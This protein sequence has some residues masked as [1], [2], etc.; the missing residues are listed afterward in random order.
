MYLGNF[1]LAVLAGIGFDAVRS[2]QMPALLWSRLTTVFKWLIIVGGGLV[3]SANIIFYI[4]SD[5][6]IKFL[7]NYYDDNYYQ[8][9][10]KPPLSHYHNVISSLV[11]SMFENVN[12]LNIKFFIPAVFIVVGYILVRR[13]RDSRI[14]IGKYFG[15]AAVAL[16]F[17]NLISLHPHYYQTFHK[18]IIQEQPEIA[19]VIKKKEEGSLNNM[20]IF[21]FLTGSG[22]D[23]KLDNAFYPEVTDKDHMIIQR[24]LM[25]VN[26]NMLYGIDTIDGYN[27]LMPRRNSRLLAVLGSHR[28]TVGDNLAY[29]EET[30]P[31][32]ISAF[33]SRLPLLSMMNVKYV[34]SCPL[35]SI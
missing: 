13:M 29:A 21:S 3:V 34:I 32:K 6:L 14:F 27:N 20:R 19:S 33:L 2:S 25:V 4:F 15:M 7:Q 24:D 16:S 18:K 23:Q 35:Q 1:G 30:I 17:V 22:I 8:Y 26:L 9:S 5:K 31:D 10:T 12:L 28:A 11:N